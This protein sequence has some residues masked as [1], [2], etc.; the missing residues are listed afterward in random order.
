[1]IIKLDYPEGATPLDPNELAGLK[2]R[3]ITT[4][5]ELDE[6]EQANIASGLRW[7][8]RMRRRDILT[9]GFAIEL[10]RRLFGE[11]WSW[12]GDFR[13]TG[14]NIGADPA[15]IAMQLRAVMDDARYWAEHGTYR[16]VEMAARLHHRL[17]WVHPF[18]NGNGRHA[19]IMADIALEKI[20]GTASIDWTLGLDL[21]RMNERRAAYIAALKA[22]DKHD[23]APLLAFVGAE[24]PK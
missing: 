23:I 7:L 20:Y 17:V 12:A 22:A 3:H 13:K 4:Q 24:K 1:M 14:K 10:H 11:V 8:A 16:P 9:D 15:R 5:G 2:H 21:Q 18:V 6:L 19:R